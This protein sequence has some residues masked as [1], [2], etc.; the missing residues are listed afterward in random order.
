M[1]S[2]KDK[3]FK[4]TQKNIISF[5]E[6]LDELKSRERKLISN[7]ISHP[8]NRNRMVPPVKDIF[9]S[10]RWATNGVKNI[11]VRDEIL[12]PG[13]SW[14]RSK[15]F[16]EG[17]PTQGTVQWIK[18]GQ[19]RRSKTCPGEGW[20]QGSYYNGSQ[21]LNPEATKGYFWITDGVESKMLAPGNKIPK[22]W[23]KGRIM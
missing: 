13:F 2:C 20:V 18:D 19:T 14:G 23:K 21:N 8:K 6:T 16:G 5:C 9:G 7:H 22:G 1:G 17:H 3:S 15:P 11:Q 10:F 12:P 4:P